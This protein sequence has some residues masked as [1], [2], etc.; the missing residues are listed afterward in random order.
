MGQGVNDPPPGETMYKKDSNA[1]R[2]RAASSVGSTPGES[3]QPPK[4]RERS[5]TL[6]GEGHDHE[7]GFP[8]QEREHM[9][10]LLESMSGTLGELLELRR[11]LRITLTS[12]PRQSS[13]LLASSRPSLREVT[14]CS[15]RIVCL[16]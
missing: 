15:L 10:E 11:R 7:E 13:S 9:T 8:A 3:N 1:R 16:L 6:A 2:S 14:S 12:A 5:S 4:G